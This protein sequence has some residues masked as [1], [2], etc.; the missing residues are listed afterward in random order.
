[1]IPALV[2]TAPAFGGVAEIEGARGVKSRSAMKRILRF[3]ERND[4]FLKVEMKVNLRNYP[5]ISIQIGFHIPKC[6]TN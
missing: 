2:Q 4:K 3:I 5:P 1:V 6:Q